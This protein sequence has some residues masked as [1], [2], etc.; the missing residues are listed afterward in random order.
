MTQAE[1][2]LATLTK[3]LAVMSETQIHTS[4]N[5]AKLTSAIDELAKAL[6][7]LSAINVRLTSLEKRLAK[8]DAQIARIPELDVCKVKIDRLEKVVYTA[9]GFLTLAILSSGVGKLLI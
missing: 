9:L 3:D 5:V 4:N 6:K 1:K 2:A 7:P 8:Q